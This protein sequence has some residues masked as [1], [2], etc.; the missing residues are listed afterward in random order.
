MSR[1]E[2]LAA[3]DGWR[4]ERTGLHQREFIETRRHW[5]SGTAPH[6]RT[7]SVDVLNLVQGA[8]A[9]IESP[10]ARFEPFVVHFAETVIIPHAAGTYTIRPHGPAEGTECATIKASVRTGANA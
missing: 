3:G 9:I 7:G 5:F 2:P 4:E 1:I 6:Q 10:A 8:Q